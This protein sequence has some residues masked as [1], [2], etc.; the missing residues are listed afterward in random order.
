MGELV[1]YFRERVIQGADAFV[2]VALGFDDYADAMKRKL[3][4]ELGG[5][6][7]WRSGS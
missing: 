1:T 7:D 2:E 5:F 3:L 6:S 4:R